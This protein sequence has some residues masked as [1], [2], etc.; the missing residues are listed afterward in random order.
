MIYTVGI[1]DGNVFEVLNT[2]LAT[3]CLMSLSPSIRYY[4]H[5][6]SASSMLAILECADILRRAMAARLESK[7]V[8]RNGE[9]NSFERRLMSIKRLAQARDYAEKI[10]LQ[11]SLNDCKWNVS[12][13]ARELGVNRKTAMRLMAKHGIKRPEK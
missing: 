12:K 7:L 10:V 3:D 1:S 8:E 13:A 9:G 11:I 6:H 4:C 2:S 5:V